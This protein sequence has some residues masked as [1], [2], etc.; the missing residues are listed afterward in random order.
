MTP[1]G[2]YILIVIMYFC[3]SK[4]MFT[5]FYCATFVLFLKQFYLFL[6]QRGF[7]CGDEIY[8]AIIYYKILLTLK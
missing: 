4:T 5:V 2:N 8:F 6:I 7:R 3:F 1:G